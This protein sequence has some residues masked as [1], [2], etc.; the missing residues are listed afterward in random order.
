MSALN[1][2]F[3]N[4]QTKRVHI[5]SVRGE[6]ELDFAMALTDRS[7]FMEAFS[8]LGIQDKIFFYVV[9]LDDDSAGLLPNLHKIESRS[10]ALLHGETHGLLRNNLT[11]FSLDEIIESEQQIYATS[12]YTNPDYGELRGTLKIPIDTD[13]FNSEKPRGRMSNLH[14]VCFIHS[15]FDAN[16]TAAMGSLGG[17]MVYDLLLQQSEIGDFKFET[18]KTRRMYFIDDPS[19]IAATS[20]P[21]GQNA[22]AIPYSGPVHY[23]SEEDNHPDG[24]VGWMAGPPEGPM[25]PRLS[26]VTLQN[27]KITSDLGSIQPVSNEIDDYGQSL[28]SQGLLANSTLMTE[29]GHISTIQD[30]NTMTR[31]IVKH[32]SINSNMNPNVIDY[33]SREMS[34]INLVTSATSNTNSAQNL[35]QSHYG[36][37]IG[38]DF[39]KIIKYRSRLGYIIDFHERNEN[40]DF[41]SSAVYYS[42]ILKLEIIRRRLTDTPYLT[43]NQDSN[44]YGKYEDEIL[45][46]KSI[47]MSSD[48]NPGFLIVQDNYEFLLRGRL[49]EEATLRGEIEEV[50]ILR[51]MI[52][53][54]NGAIIPHPPKRYNREFI[55]RDYDL[56]HN[57]TCGKYTYLVDIILNDGVSKMV[58]HL[59]SYIERTQAA[60][61]VLLSRAQQPFVVTSGRAT[62]NYDYSARRFARDFSLDVNNIEVS[63]RAIASYN[64]AVRF[65]KGTGLSQGELQELESK[66]NLHVC[67]I[68]DLF[69]FHSGLSEVLSSIRSISQT[70]ISNY[71]SENYSKNKKNVQ[72]AGAGLIDSI[73][74]LSKT[75]IVAD[76]FSETD[77][78]A[79]Y[80]SSTD[81]SPPIFIP[82]GNLPGTYNGVLGDQ[83]RNVLVT[84][85]RFGFVHTT[86]N[87]VILNPGLNN[88]LNPPSRDIES[89]LS[90]DRS[91]LVETSNREEFYSLPGN[92]QSAENVKLNFLTSDREISRHFT[93]MPNEFYF[94]AIQSYYGGIV[95]APTNS[96]TTPLRNFFEDFSVLIDHLRPGLSEATK[97]TICDAAYTEDDRGLFLESVLETLKDIVISRDALGGFY[98]IFHNRMTLINSLGTNQV[99]RSYANRFQEATPLPNPRDPVND[100]YARHTRQ[101]RLIDLEGNS[102]QIN[103]LNVAT[104]MIQPQD[105][106]L[107]S[108]IKNIICL[109]AEAMYNTDA[110][111][112]NDLI[113]VE[114]NQ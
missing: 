31:N 102:T 71:R 72:H 41:I 32:A 29:V 38:I 95:L 35:G 9:L 60:L 8:S 22:T 91:I 89:G 66:L 70:G 49:Q 44:I 51:T 16:F 23:H 48:S 108:N 94:K 83:I 112:M 27:Y 62:G 13:Y 4:I 107:S 17:H 52:S 26:L 79:D 92:T 1:R 93:D 82:A 19:Y 33:G 101:F 105:N 85:R 88:E 109:K 110:V 64:R 50:Q 78:F 25:G 63:E 53:P 73:T 21:P 42:N 96:T 81:R 80:S 114:V 67:K 65:I 59:V 28:A 36:A 47:V 7:A 58:E 30:G 18:P 68:E 40:H 97:K 77:I 37:A 90:E 103:S 2:L 12:D 54:D 106:F 15:D 43:N 111:I 34:S 39:L 24:Y 87:I 5:S 57:V 99:L 11:R 20:P 46:D 61:L 100:V 56:F 86:P 10:Q 76:S 14:M 45:N 75:G 104:E 3:P 6:M 98:D 74:I 69:E 113:F 55:V 84:P